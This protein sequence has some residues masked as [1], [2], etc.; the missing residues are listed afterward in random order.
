VSNR[1]ESP[2]R[3]IRDTS[4]VI[5]RGPFAL[6][7]A[8]RDAHPGSSWNDVR[9][10]VRTGKVTVDGAIVV[11][12]TAMVG[13]G[14]SIAVRMAA[15]RRAAPGQVTKD[16]LV[17]VDSHIVVVDKPAGIATVP[18]DDERDTLD[19]LV[20]SLLRK[21][22]RPGT[23]V[24][25]LGVVQRLDKETS[26]L[27]VFSRTTTAKRELQQQLRSH[28]MH[29]RYVAL[30]N[31]KVRAG[32]IRSRL[33]QDRGDGR[34]GSTGRDDLGRESVTHVRVVEQFARAALI[35]CRLE[36]GRTHQI[37]IHLSEARNPL[38]GERVYSRGFDDLLAAPRILLHAAELGFVHPITR[39][40]LRFSRPVPDDMVAVIER[41][42]AVRAL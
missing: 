13:T 25:P 9:R 39:E 36:T 19:R 42:R 11:D 34:R 3:V 15:P 21:T 2:P 33:V 26:G 1:P 28:S 31:G 41:E 30:A 20:Q 27:L 6:D 4:F 23:T 38:V 5:E 29:R 22:A 18:H 35:E 8:L 32:T 10:I 12:P 16:V 24:P 7:R 17:H 14:S 37:R 40:E